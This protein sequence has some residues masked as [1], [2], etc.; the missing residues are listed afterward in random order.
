[1]A[2][3]SPI[4]RKMYFYPRPPWGGRLPAQVLPFAACVISIHALRGEGD[5]V[6]PPLRLIETDFYPRPPWGGRLEGR[7]MV[8]ISITFLSTPSVG[9]ATQGRANERGRLQISIHA[10]RGE[11][12]FSFM[13]M[14]RG[15][16]RFLSTPSVGRATAAA[17]VGYSENFISIHALRGEG[18]FGGRF[19]RYKRTISIHAL[20]GEGDHRKGSQRRRNCF[21]FYPRPPWGGRR[22][23]H[24]Q[25]QA[26]SHISIHALRGEGDWSRGCETWPEPN[27]YPRPPWGGRQNAAA[28]AAAGA[29]FYPRPPW[30]G[31]QQPPIQAFTVKRI[32]IHALRGE[33]DLGSGKQERPPQNFYPRPPWGGRLRKH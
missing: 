12:D 22:Q 1:M 24:R 31:R 5:G 13:W 19:D 29:D 26:G 20:R 32:S 15:N 8:A 2:V 33:G 18:D 11:G 14:C 10:L 9:R 16:G 25:Q 6:K 17:A 21:Y 7:Q 28:W 30:G 3:V 23:L 27:F 4:S